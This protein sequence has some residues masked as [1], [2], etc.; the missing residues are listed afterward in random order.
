M[1]DRS[2]TWLGSAKDDLAAAAALEP[3]SHATSAYLYQQAAE[4]ALKALC[5]KVGEPADRTHNIVVLW[6]RLAALGVL[7]VAAPQ[8]VNDMK[9]LTAL[10][11]EARYPVHDETMTP[12][13]WIDTLDVERARQTSTGIVE[14]VSAL[15]AGPAETQEGPGP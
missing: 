7:P 8:Q 5:L 10:H 15:L 4:K 2:A 6:N 3:T 11:I 12:S 1:T 13:Q 14:A 9:R